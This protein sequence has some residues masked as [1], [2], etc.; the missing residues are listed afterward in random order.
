MLVMMMKMKMMKTTPLITTMQIMGAVMVLVSS[1]M[2]IVVE[3][4][5]ISMVSSTITKAMFSVQS[6]M[7]F[8]W[9]WQTSFL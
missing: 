1:L 6:P 8:P 5:L 9:A 2:L 3:T 7:R 4:M